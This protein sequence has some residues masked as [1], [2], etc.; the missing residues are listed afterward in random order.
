ML[1]TSPQSPRDIYIH[2][3][4]QMYTC[5]YIYIDI[6]IYTWLCTSSVDFDMGSVS[7]LVLNTGL[8]EFPGYSKATPNMHLIHQLVMLEKSEAWQNPQMSVGGAG[9]GW[10]SLTWTSQSAQH[11]GPISQNKV[12]NI[13]A[14]YPKIESVGRRGSTI[15]GTVG[16][17]PL[18]WGT[19][20]GPGKVQI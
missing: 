2:I 19:F 13:M 10:L 3:Y 18:F 6:H 1:N 5:I 20:G 7:G 12:P 4:V 15:L 11:N 9:A 8:V 16:E 14:P 17:G